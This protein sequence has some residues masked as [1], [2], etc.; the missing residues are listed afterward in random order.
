MADYILRADSPSALQSGKVYLTEE[1]A[2]SFTKREA[3]VF[4]AKTRATE[5]KKAADLE[6]EIIAPDFETNQP[7]EEAV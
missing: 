4:T 3:K 5:G 1:G 7:I 6:C 2:W